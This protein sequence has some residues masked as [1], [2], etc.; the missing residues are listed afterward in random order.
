MLPAPSTFNRLVRVPADPLEHPGR[1]AHT[2]TPA[3]V[4][5]FTPAVALRPGELA[6]VDTTRLDVMAVGE[7]GRTVRPE[8]TISL[9][10]ATPSVVATVLREEGTQAVDAALLAE[11]A[12]PHPSRPGRPA[13]L[14]LAHA[15]I[16]YT[17]LP[18]LDA[19]L[20]HAAARPVVVPETIVIGRGMVFVSAAFLA[21]CETLE[22]GRATRAA[23]VP[24]HQRR[25]RA[26]LR[27]YQQPFSRSTPPTTPAP[28][29]F[30]AAG[31]W[32]M[33]HASP[34][35]SCRSCWTSGPP[36]PG[37]TA[38]TTGC[39]TRCCRRRRWPRT[40]CGARC[41]ASGY[42]PLP[43]TGAD[44]LQLPP[45]RSHPVTGRGIRINYR[46]YD[47]VVLNEHRS[48]PGHASPDAAPRS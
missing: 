46:T 15:T 3:P 5:P 12:V 47:H 8:V 14:R 2:A 11:M 26:Y 22:G 16:P 24:R 36:R 30:S 48:R 29:S 25:R 4:R 41:C 33:K 45:M 17:R 28:T 39:A 44:Y 23:A 9:D 42:L 43:L 20:A 19:R 6:Q 27:Q 34:W 18:T 35:P 32:R 21:A 13:H 10:V 7:D 31:Q 38:P 40:G 37:S 1:P